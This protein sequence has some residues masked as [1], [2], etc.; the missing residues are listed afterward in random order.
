MPCV[1]LESHSSKGFSRAM[2]LLSVPEN[3]LS[4]GI[5]VKLRRPL[6]FLEIG[7]KL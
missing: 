1:I 7:E 3:F 2:F 4:V 6:S 5:K